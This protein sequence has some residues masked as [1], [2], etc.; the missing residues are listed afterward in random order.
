MV[1]R[2]V[3]CD[4]LIPPSRKP[5]VVE[6]DQTGDESSYSVSPW[7]P[8]VDCVK[9]LQYFTRVGARRVVDKEYVIHIPGVK[10]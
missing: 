1:E 6:N 9:V 3:D 2:P 5:I 8:A 7:S 10:G 4:I